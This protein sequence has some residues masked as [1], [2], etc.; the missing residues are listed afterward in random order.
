[1]KEKIKHHLPFIIAASI[2]IFALFYYF[3]FRKPEPGPVNNQQFQPAS[4]PVS[5]LEMDKIKTKNYY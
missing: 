1:M 4:P 2:V 5:P 3:F